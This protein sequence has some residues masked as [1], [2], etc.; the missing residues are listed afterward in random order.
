MEITASKVEELLKATR[1]PVSL[2]TPLSGE[3]ASTLSHIIE[4]RNARTPDEEAARNIMKE[5]I[6]EALGT[7]NEREAGI[8]TLRFGLKGERSRTLEEVGRE[9]GVTRER[10]RQIEAAA[11][12]KMRHPSRSRKLRDFLE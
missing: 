3:D 11:L 4:D 10:I 8:L 5:Q 1:E 9:Y 7:L 2:D 6:K 12:Q